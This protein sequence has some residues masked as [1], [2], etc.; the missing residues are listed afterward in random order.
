VSTSWATG[1]AFL[2][3]A[4]YGTITHINPAAAWGTI[5]SDLGETL[6]VNITDDESDHTP[7]LTAGM[8]VQFTWSGETTA[9]G[10]PIATRIH[11]AESQLPAHRSHHGHPPGSTAP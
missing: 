3:V 6:R 1:D 2:G 5:V 11:L 4:R 10:T 9:D 7:W 8:R